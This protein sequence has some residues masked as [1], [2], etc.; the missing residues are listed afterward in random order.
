MGKDI[1]ESLKSRNVL[2]AFKINFSV[3]NSGSGQTTAIGR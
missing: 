2:L 1:P 3:Q